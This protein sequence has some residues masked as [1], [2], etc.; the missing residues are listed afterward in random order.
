MNN[1]FVYGLLRGTKDS[2][3]GTNPLF[4][5]EDFTNEL[6]PGNELYTLLASV[7]SKFK[8]S[9]RPILINSFIEY[10]FFLYV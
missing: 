10:L 8:Y 4:S 1:V 5:S 6:A 9:I 3:K 7:L 2:K